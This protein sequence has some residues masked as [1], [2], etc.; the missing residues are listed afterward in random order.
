M[1]RNIRSRLDRLERLAPD[2]SVSRFWDLLTADRSSLAPDDLEY[3]RSLL[4]RPPGPNPINE[5]VDSLL[6][7]AEEAIRLVGLP[8]PDGTVNERT[9]PSPDKGE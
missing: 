9:E 8:S 3:L 7:E 5:R 4:G 1:S 2:P 6:A